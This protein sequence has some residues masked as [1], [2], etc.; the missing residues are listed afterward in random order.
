[1]VVVRNASSKSR[2]NTRFSTN[3]HAQAAHDRAYLSTL[4]CDGN[5]VLHCIV[6]VQLNML[7]TSIQ[8]PTNEIYIPR[9][10]SCYT[11]RLALLFT[12]SV[13]VV[14]KFYSWFKFYFPLSLS[15]L[16]YDNEFK[17]KVESKI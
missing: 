1:M 11:S 4:Q 15:T 16:I 13:Y 8:I 2:F 6:L 10:L 7:S 3:A 9:M 5:A 14:V 12:C 17:T